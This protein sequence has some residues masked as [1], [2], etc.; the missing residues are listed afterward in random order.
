MKVN[1]RGMM[2]EVLARLQQLELAN[3]ALQ[4]E[5]REAQK[6]GEERYRHDRGAAR[7]EAE[8]T[9]RHVTE[10][11]AAA[12]ARMMHLVPT[13][14]DTKLTSKRETFSGKDAEWPRWSLTL[15][16]YH[17]RGNDYSCQCYSIQNTFCKKKLTNVIQ[18]F[19]IT[20]MFFR[21][22][23]DVR[24]LFH[25]STVN[26]STPTLTNFPSNFGCDLGSS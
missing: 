11:T 5:L 6:L 9:A 12:T 10:T 26:A 16:V 20:Q 21:T 3:A 1:V 19:L 23:I 4:A 17:A 8:E 7:Q 15:R 25:S 2:E 18:Y 14:V 24:S 22:V 13:S